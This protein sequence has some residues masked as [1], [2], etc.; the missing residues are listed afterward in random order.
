MQFSTLSRGRYRPQG[1]SYL[2]PRP[3]NFYNTCGP[4]CLWGLV[5]GVEAWII[6]TSTILTDTDSVTATATA[7]ATKV[8]SERPLGPVRLVIGDIRG[9]SRPFGGVVVFGRKIGSVSQARYPRTT[10]TVTA[11]ATVTE[12]PPPISFSSPPNL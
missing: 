10:A 5:V 1:V 9:A 12:I 2:P 11:T 3:V 7:T 4:D 6:I 8:V